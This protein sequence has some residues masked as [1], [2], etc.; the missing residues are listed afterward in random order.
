[1]QHPLTIEKDLRWLTNKARYLIEINPDY[2][3]NRPLL[4]RSKVSAID[5]IN[6]QSILMHIMPA[7]TVCERVMTLSNEIQLLLHTQDVD[8]Q[9]IFK[10]HFDRAFNYLT[11]KDDTV[12]RDFE[13]T[14]VKKMAAAVKQLRLPRQFREVMAVN[15]ML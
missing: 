6:R 8:T 1:M 2:Y 3:T 15:D 11:G 4:L 13:F 14:K 9:L 7:K 12:G 5:A 10:N